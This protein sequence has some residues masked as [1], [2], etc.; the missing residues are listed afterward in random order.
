MISI[1]QKKTGSDAEVVE[2]THVDFPL[3]VEQQLNC[4][5]PAESARTPA[6]TQY[7][8]GPYPSKHEKCGNC[9]TTQVL[10]PWGKNLKVASDHNGLRLN[11]ICPSCGLSHRACIFSDNTWGWIPTKTYHCGHRL[12]SKWLQ[13]TMKAPEEFKLDS[14]NKRLQKKYQ[15]T[16]EQGSVQNPPYREPKSTIGY[17]VSPLK[18]PGLTP[19]SLTRPAA[20]IRRKSLPRLNTDATQSSLKRS[21][22]MSHKQGSPY[23]ARSVWYQSSPVSACPTLNGRAETWA[24]SASY[25][26]FR[27][28]AKVYPMSNLGEHIHSEVGSSAEGKKK[29]QDVIHDNISHCVPLTE[30]CDNDENALLVRS[31]SKLALYAPQPVRRAV[32]ADQL[33]STTGETPCR[34][35]SR[36]LTDPPSVLLPQGLSADYAGD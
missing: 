11:Q 14:K 8:A 23:V 13:Y 12:D 3:I 5:Q 32:T 1:L 7:S 36:V 15:A 10:I 31:V 20:I 27:E 2:K 4:A 29:I 16:E 24:R 18:H 26:E 9:E 6:I 28:K 25:L 33:L 30:Q 34:L 22:A 19:S 35:A 21:R 17:P